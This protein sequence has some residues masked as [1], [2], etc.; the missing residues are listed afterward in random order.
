VDHL[1]QVK[2]L[3][4]THQVILLVVVALAIVFSSQTAFA[5]QTADLEFKAIVEKPAYT[6]NYPRVLFDE[7]HNNFHTTKGR[8]KPFVDLVT[9]DGYNVVGSRKV[10]TRASLDTFKIV[11]IANALGAEDDDEDGADSS[12]FTPDEIQAVHDWVRG[13]GALLL[14]ADHAPFGGAA[15]ALAKQF[16]VAMSKGFVFDPEHSQED[17]PSILTFSREN[18]LL[19]DHP[20]TRGRE[21]AEKINRVIAFTGQALKTTE[22]NSVFLKLGEGAKDKPSR[23]AETDVSVAGQAQGLAFKFGKGRVVILG[24]AAMLSAQISGPT[25]MPMGMNVPDTDNKQ[26]ALNIMH[27]LSGMLK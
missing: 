19:L 22:P 11:I 13:G 8:Y 5:Q 7:A 20:I 9:S 23:T 25:K 15:E 2:T 27:W 18:K 3:M 10:F 17:A 4:K 16:G 1:G 6:R 14:I 21:D 12:A 26:L 24:E